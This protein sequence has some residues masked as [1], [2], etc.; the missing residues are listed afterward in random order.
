MPLKKRRKITVEEIQDSV[1]SVLQR[2]G[3]REVPRLTFYIVKQREKIR[4]MK[5]AVLDYKE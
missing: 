2:A 3:L 5:S 1:E 4:Y